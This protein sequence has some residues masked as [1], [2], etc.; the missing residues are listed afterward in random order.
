MGCAVIAS[1]PAR[2]VVIGAMGVI[3]NMGDGADQ[4]SP[5]LQQQLRRQTWSGSDRP[6]FSIPAT[7]SM[8]VFFALCA[9]C[10]ATLITIRRETQR[11][12]WAVFTFVYMTLLAYAGAFV[13]YQIGIRWLG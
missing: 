13:T 10:G 8:L 12:G 5:Q 4:E 3:F 11:V 1:F 2:E 6:L 9:Q 7:L